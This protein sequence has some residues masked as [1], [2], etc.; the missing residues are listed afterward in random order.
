ML[1]GKADMA[2][3]YRWFVLAILFSVSVVNTTGKTLIPALAELLRLEFVLSDSE[4]GF[5]LA[6]WSALTLLCARFPQCSTTGRRI[7]YGRR[8][9]L[10]EE[11]RL[12]C[13]RP[14]N[15]TVRAGMNI[16]FF[17][18]NREQEHLQP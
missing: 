11:R 4:L 1:N 6:T 16:S 12:A 10:N 18:R 13:C 3:N 2:S 17:F 8:I 5:L 9:L 7:K 15:R 14:G